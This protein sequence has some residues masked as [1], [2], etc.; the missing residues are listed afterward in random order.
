MSV[1][2]RY[3]VQVDVPGVLG[4]TGITLVVM[5]IAQLA[6]VAVAALDPA[7][8]AAPL[9]I[10]AL[11]TS[12]FGFALLPLRTRASKWTRRE[13]LAI[14]ALSWVSAVLAAAVPY[15]ALGIGVVDALV[16]SMSGLT[17]TGATVLP[18]VDAI[19]APLHLW[20]SLTHWLGG[21]GIV[22][23]VLVLAP[24]LGNAEEL[25]RT[26][27]SEASFLTERYRGSTRA[28]LKGLLVVYVGA[29]AVLF[30]ILMALGMSGWDAINHAFATISTGGFSTRTASLGYWD[31]KIQMVTV[32]FMVLGA[33]SFATLGRVFVQRDPRALFKNGEVRAYLVMLAVVAAVVT[34]ILYLQGDP[35]RYGNHGAAGFGQAFVDASFTV[36][37]ISTTT[38]FGTVNYAT[39]PSVCQVILLGL[40]L[41]GGCSGST[42]GGIKFR[43][44]MVLWRHAYLEMRRLANP[45]AVIPQQMSGR[46]V[47]PEELREAVA[48]VAFYGLLIMI[49]SVLI[50]GTGSDPVSSGAMSVSSMGSIGPAFGDA[51]PTGSFAPYAPFAKMIAVF[52]MLLGRLEIFPILTVVLPSFWL[53]RSD[54][55]AAA[56]PS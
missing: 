22:L 47:A 6:L 5:G 14:V 18:D 23:I 39:W 28:T 44:V 20:R 50:A 2:P 35:D 43:R 42:A 33:L 40:M 10:G 36:T 8:R 3:R 45:R 1:G 30:L 46:V 41:I 48:Y 25:R 38:G 11:A 13:S 21:A 54:I 7:T 56:R 4:T 32:A 27:R 15:V 31:W 37:A 12:L 34:S 49:F 26:Q 17:T 53:R 16:E 9:L 24:W 29:T 55:P 51:D 19:P 52:A